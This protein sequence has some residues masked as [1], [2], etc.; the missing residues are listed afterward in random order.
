MPM[1]LTLKGKDRKDALEMF[2]LVQ[3]YMGDRP[4]KVKDINLCALDCI[5]RGWT[6][7]SVIQRRTRRRRRRR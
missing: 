6:T 5:T 1:L 3:M 4:T 2:K 7:A